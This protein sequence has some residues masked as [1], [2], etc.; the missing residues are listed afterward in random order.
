MS[1]QH[2]PANEDQRADLISR[3]SWADF[4]GNRLVALI[5]NNDSSLLIIHFAVLV[6]A[7]QGRAALR[8]RRWLNTN[9]ISPTTLQQETFT[10]AQIAIA[11]GQILDY[12]EESFCGKEH[13]P[14]V[15][16]GAGIQQHGY[17]SGGGWAAR[18][19]RFHL[20]R[21]NET[22]DKQTLTKTP[23]FRVTE[24]D[25]DCNLLKGALEMSNRYPESRIG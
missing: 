21:L 17:F 9:L 12:G 1:G 10:D 4:H 14:F 20:S 11:L 7:R 16:V 22:I 15:G 23:V 2:L 8:R 18:A 25:C 13:V 19:L 3:E 24:T 5:R 6:A